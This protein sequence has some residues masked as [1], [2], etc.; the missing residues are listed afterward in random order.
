M[1]EVSL[2]LRTTVLRTILRIAILTS[3]LGLFAQ[4]QSQTAFRPGGQP[5]GMVQPNSPTIITVP[6]SPTVYV[7]GGGMYGAYLTPLATVPLQET[8]ISL[9]DRQGISLGTVLQTGA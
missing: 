2:M 9:A 5:A 4:Q 1:R 6:A 3:W 7:V 8:G